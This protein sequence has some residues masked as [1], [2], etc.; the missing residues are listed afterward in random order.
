M[1]SVVKAFTL[2]ELLVSMAVL[3]LLLV[4]L[5]GLVD[6]GTKL[7]RENEGRAEIYREARAALSIIE[8]DLRN[9]ISKTDSPKLF[10]LNSDAFSKLPSSAQANA[11]N[12]SALF[13]LSAQPS[14]AFGASSKSDVCEVGYFLAFGSS[15]ANPSANPASAPGTMNLYRYFR[16]GDSAYSNLVANTSFPSPTLTGNE[17]ELLAR[18]IRSFRISAFST[19]SSGGLVPYSGS[20]DAPLPELVEISLVAVNQELA[21]KLGSA[22]DWIS[23][24]SGITNVMQRVEQE[25]SVRVRTSNKK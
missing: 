13:F 22:S 1:K 19:N 3:A 24:P 16:T 25:F 2:I 6:S 9:G 17:T 15:S 18:N 7:W 11:T 23:P 8:R 21:N 10:L 12:A 5:L 4:M 20:P 14:S